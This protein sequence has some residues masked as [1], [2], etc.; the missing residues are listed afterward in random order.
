MA[1][2]ECLEDAAPQAPSGGFKPQ[3]EEH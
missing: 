3:D 2:A 1:D